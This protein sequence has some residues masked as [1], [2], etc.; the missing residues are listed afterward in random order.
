M[1]FTQLINALLEFIEVNSMVVVGVYLFEDFTQFIEIVEKMNKFLEFAKFHE[2]I[3]IEES[4]STRLASKTS[5]SGSFLLHLNQRL[6]RL[7]SWLF[8]SFRTADRNVWSLDQFQPTTNDRCHCQIAWTTI[9]EEKVR[10]LKWED[11][12]NRSVRTY[13]LHFLF[14]R[15]LCHV[16]CQRRFSWLW[17][18]FFLRFRRRLIRLLNVM[19]HTDLARERMENAFFFCLTSSIDRREEKRF[20][21]GYRPC[22]FADK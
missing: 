3:L 2:S 13:L 17:A 22:L 11:G 14:A 5:S 9:D 7:S 21:L 15:F 6:C 12:E 1:A 18:S 19:I 4:N 20:L 16:L 8:C 10:S